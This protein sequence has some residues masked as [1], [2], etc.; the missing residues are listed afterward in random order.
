MKVL[1]IARGHGI[2]GVQ[3]VGYR[4]FIYTVAARNGVAASCENKPDYT[5]HFILAG[6]QEAIYKTIAAARK[7]PGRARVL[8][9]DVSVIEE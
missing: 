5:V 2:S 1:C 3:H 8:A 4:R 6:T 9:V 7:G